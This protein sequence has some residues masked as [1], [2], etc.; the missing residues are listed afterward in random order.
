MG[1]CVCMAGGG[2][3]VMRVVGNPTR[4]KSP[5]TSL[6]PG[7][8]G[9]AQ[10][11]GQKAHHQLQ[12]LPSTQTTPHRPGEPGPPLLPTESRTCLSTPKASGNP[13]PP[14]RGPTCAP[15]STQQEPQP[16][17]NNWLCRQGT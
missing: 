6:R 4:Q 2:G 3:G 15:R 10:Q 8:E 13:R 16:S 12:E 1:L 9:P 11:G 7:R 14:A 17:G 5:I